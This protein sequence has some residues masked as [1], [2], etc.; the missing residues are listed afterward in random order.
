MRLAGSHATRHPADGPRR[1]T[2]AVRTSTDRARRAVNAAGLARAI[3]HFDGR[4]GVT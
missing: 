3:R 4:G 2:Q 1:S